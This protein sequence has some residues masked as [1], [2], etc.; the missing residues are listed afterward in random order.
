MFFMKKYLM[1]LAS[2]ALMAGVSSCI[3]DLDVT[4]I[5]PNLTPPDEVLDSE[6]AFA[7]VLAKCY[8]GLTVSASGGPDSSPDIDGI[9]G[10]YGQYTRALF[11]TNELPT[12]EAMSCWND[13]TLAN[14]H[15][16]SWTSSDV[17]VTAMFSRAY[18]Q[19]SL[20][21]EFI[22]KAQASEFKDS[23]NMKTYI[24]EARALRALSYWHVI[25]MFG[26]GPFATEN[27]SVGSSAP[28]GIS[29]IDLLDWLITECNSL[30]EEG[31]LKP[32]MG[33]VY[34]R[35]DEGFVMMILA[36][37]YINSEV[38]SNGQLSYMNEAAAIC[39]DIMAA[40]PDLYENYEHLFMADNHLRTGEIIFN[41]PQD[42]VNIQTYG[43]TNF[44]I[45][46]SIASG[47]TAWQAAMGVNDG[48]GGIMVTP[49]L[50]NKF[51]DGD[52]R[53]MFW[54]GG[55]EGDYPM[56]I[57]DWKNFKS[58]WQTYKFRNIKSDG[59]AAQA[60]NFPD[61]DLPLFRT[62]DAYLMLAEAYL[63]GASN[64]T[65]A[66]AR[67]AWNAVRHRA[68][69]G[70][71][72][73]FTLDELIDERARELYFECFRRSDLVRFGKLTSDEY[74]WTWKGNV[75]EGTAVLDKFNIF[76]IPV[77]EINCNP[78]L[79]DLQNPGY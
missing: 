13:Q 59:S 70:D 54:G 51:E 20:C 12:D 76:P 71:V 64:V 22:R 28:E 25:D 7:Q 61:T 78:N 29:R 63:R 17:F 19:I 6:D 67:E 55:P 41:I 24:A 45:K 10:G 53:K 49:E 33:N 48:W 43:G 26:N 72:T 30:L 52:A 8:A 39:K 3:G 40:Y 11:Y 66:E 77:N 23:Q 9:D 42:G 46:A 21:N 73:D 47:E 35:L 50:I 14:L 4:P 27:N 68:K 15:G 1:I 38:Y 34:G 62:A 36:K 65:E 31:N 56:D 74:L 79:K 60:Q 75:K 2:V 44:L 58:G 32:V 57:A 37:L 5:D 16:L 69:I 18:Y